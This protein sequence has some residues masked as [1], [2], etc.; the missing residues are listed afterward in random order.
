LGDSLLNSLNRLNKDRLIREV[1]VVD[2]DPASLRM[3]EKL[4]QDQRDYKLVL[5]HGGEDA[6]N[7]L[8]HHAPD[9]VILDL[10]MPDLD[11]FKL[12]ERMRESPGLRH[13]PVV[14][15]SGGD[16]SPDQRA[17]LTDFGHRLVAK[18]ALNEA[19]LFETIRRAL[20]RVRRTA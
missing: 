1:L 18:S 10:F 11:G 9:A 20:H 14:V 4:F 2:D 19:E 8:T 12:L 6:W 7:A 15:V 5:S 16:L 13:I 17:E 3:M